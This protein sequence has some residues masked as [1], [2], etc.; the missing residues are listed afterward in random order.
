M[1]TL[2]ARYNPWWENGYTFKDLKPRNAVMKPIFDSLNDKRISLITGM[3]RIGKSSIL[4]LVI[5]NLF[6]NGVEP[7]FIFF[8]SLDEYSIK[9]LSI[10]EILDSYRKIMRIKYDDRIYV[11]LDEIT[12][13][14]DFELQ[15]KNLYDN[16][17]IKI[18]ASSSNS[19]AL[20][21]KKAY[22]TGR[23]KVFEIQPLNFGE[24]MEFK[25]LIIKQSDNHLKEIYFEDFLRDGGIPEYVLTGNFDYIKDLV[26]DIIY[27]DIAAMHNIKDVS[28]LK[29][30]FL[31]LME[32]SG[33]QLSINKMAS[34]LSIY[35]DTARRYLD[36]FSRTY[37]IQLVARYG[38]TNERITA[39]K[40]V[41]AIDNGIRNYFTGFRDK[42]SLFE[43]YTYQRIKY[44]NPSYVYQNTIEIDFYTQNGFLIEAKYHQEKLSDKQQS[45]F[46]SFPSNRKYIVRSDSDIET[47]LESD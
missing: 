44:L 1:E 8:I 13:K 28:L 29:D 9:D 17:N 46:D 20:E 47:L 22:L 5:K 41:Y 39:P 3:R 35:P 15:L 45:L 12:Y 14:N 24:Y 33:K 38:K 36:F 2:F 18:F 43:T 10:V 37:L 32:R 34:I 11:F 30:F 4:R 25:N 40:K 26:D 42:G 27:K 6:E 23:T 21:D 31:L 7:K 16:Q 19:I